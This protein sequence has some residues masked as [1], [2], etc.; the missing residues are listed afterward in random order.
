MK[1][2]RALNFTLSLVA[3]VGFGFF[4]ASCTGKSMDGMVVFTQTS[5]NGLA[6][7][8]DKAAKST[9]FAIDPNNVGQPAKLLTKDFYSASTPVISFDGV[10]MLF[11]AKKVENDNLQIWEMTLASSKIRQV[12]SFSGNCIDPAYL[13]N[14]RILFSSSSSKDTLRSGLPLFTCN[15]EGADLKQITF[16]HDTYRASSVLRDGRVLTINQSNLTDQKK[17]RLMV[18]RPDGTKAEFFYQGNMESTIFSKPFESS[19]GNIVFIESNS[20]SQKGTN[21]TS[22]SYNRPLHSRVNLTSG[23]KGD[24]RSVFPLSSGK[25]LVSYRAGES[26]KYRLYE[27]DPAGKALGKLFYEKDGFVIADIVVVEKLERPKKLPSEVDLGVK[28]GLLLCQDINV[29][30]PEW[31][32]KSAVLKKAA[33]IEVMGIDSSMG[34]VPVEKDGSFYLKL[35]ADKPFQIRTLDENGQILYQPCNWMWLRPNERRGCVGCHE[36]HEQ[37]PENRVPLAVKNAP[38]NI[39]VHIVKIIEKKVSL[40]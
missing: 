31:L 35:I 24:F 19:N 5:V 34:I 7:D 6:G 29:L 30:D 14:G 18:M 4:F 16:N 9:I 22:I 21:I 1:F 12:T 28:T 37:V 25:L 39:P 17:S 23:L 2:K 40:E 8:L 36:D 3:I 13:P 27:Y 15:L 26:E 32:N 11:S 10:N 33:S 38:V 20:G